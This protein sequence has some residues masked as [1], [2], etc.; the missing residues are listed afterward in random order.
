MTR[1]EAA[2]LLRATSA[3]S[4]R[5]DR[6]YSITL[7][8]DIRR[9]IAD[10]LDPPRDGL[11]EVTIALAWED[12]GDGKCDVCAFGDNTWTPT[13]GEAFA[14]LVDSDCAHAPTIIRAW[15]APPDRRVAEVEGEVEG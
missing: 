8:D 15:V 6:D 10:L 12:I 3:P 1:K 4:D 2:A 9:T 11:V 7:S 5:G 14:N 13:R